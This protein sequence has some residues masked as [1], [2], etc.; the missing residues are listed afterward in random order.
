LCENCWFCAA[1]A[2]AEH[3]HHHHLVLLQF[4]AKST[5]WLDKRFV[6]QCVKK[7]MLDFVHNKQTTPTFSNSLHRVY[8]TGQGSFVKLEGCCIEAWD[9]SLPK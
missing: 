3:H 2:A 1:A 6:D 9:W 5:L 4:L 7:F 8:L